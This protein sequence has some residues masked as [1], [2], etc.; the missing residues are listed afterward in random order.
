MPTLQFYFY[1]KESKISILVI[2]FKPINFYVFIYL[3][4]ILT[5][6][7]DTQNCRNNAKIV[8][9][10]DY[11]FRYTICIVLCGFKYLP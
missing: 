8:A 11:F 2:I 7:K 3:K 9:F 6:P 4:L 1:V 5:T 10:S